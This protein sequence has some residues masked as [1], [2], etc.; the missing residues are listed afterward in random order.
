MTHLVLRAL[1]D[2]GVLD[3]YAGASKPKRAK[4]AAAAAE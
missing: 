4:T 1:K 3:V 2:R